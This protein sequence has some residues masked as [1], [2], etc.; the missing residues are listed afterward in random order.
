[1]QIWSVIEVP[2]SKL[3]A[4][5]KVTW[6]FNDTGMCDVN[7]TFYFI[8]ITAKDYEIQF[9]YVL[10]ESRGKFPLGNKKKNVSTTK[11][12]MESSERHHS[13]QLRGWRVYFPVAVVFVYFK[14]L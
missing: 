11:H 12:S 9:T 14:D 2:F 6:V 7:F 5:F 10:Y 13:R 8:I 3:Q 4:F 1:M